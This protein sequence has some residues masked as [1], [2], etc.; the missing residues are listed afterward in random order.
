MLDADLNGKDTKYFLYE[1][2]M[3]ALMLLDMLVETYSARRVCSL[4]DVK[5]AAAEL[6]LA[7]DD[8]FIQR[9]LEI[10][11]ALGAVSWFPKV[12]RSLVVLDPQWLL[13]AQS[14]G[15]RGD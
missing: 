4:E 3:R 11:T 10:F 15:R 8:S 7:N 2:P 13:M 9:L 12:D 5:N 6:G 14:S 1:M